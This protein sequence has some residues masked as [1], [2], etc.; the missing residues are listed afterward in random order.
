MI[1]DLTDPYSG[2]HHV[3]G[4]TWDHHV[5]FIYPDHTIADP[6]TDRIPVWGHLPDNEPMV[7]GQTLIHRY[8]HHWVR[9]EVDTVEP[10]ETSGMFYASLMITHVWLLDA[11]LVWQ[12]R[13]RNWLR[14]TLQSWVTIN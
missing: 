12:R 7:V 6:Q 8:T 4:G 10:A 11:E 14:D 1:L 5:S 2:A 9:F 3:I 13:A